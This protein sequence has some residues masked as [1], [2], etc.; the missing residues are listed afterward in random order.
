MSVIFGIAWWALLATGFYL[1][2]TGVLNVLPTATPLPDGV[3]N[4][5]TLI[6]GY[7]QLFNFLFPI[8]TLFTILLLALSF[9]T[10]IYLWYLGRWLLGLVA[11]FFGA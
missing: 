2:F 4:A 1:F 8:D 9:Q 5:I 6:F 11:H 3:S 7:M 10:A